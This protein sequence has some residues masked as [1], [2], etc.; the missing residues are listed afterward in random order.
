[1]THA[2]IAKRRNG[3]KKADVRSNFDASLFLPDH[4]GQSRDLA[5]E[6]NARHLGVELFAQ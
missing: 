3:K 1:M 5:T 4:L 6:S 2:D